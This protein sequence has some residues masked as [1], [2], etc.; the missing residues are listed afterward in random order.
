MKKNPVI[1]V[2][3]LSGGVT[4]VNIRHG[5]LTALLHS[6]KI[7]TKVLQNVCIFPVLGLTNE[8]KW[9]RM[10]GEAV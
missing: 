7:I 1:F 9:E 10:E 5:L 6:C 3:E 4:F 2:E 8:K